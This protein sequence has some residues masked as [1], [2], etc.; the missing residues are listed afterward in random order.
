MHIYIYIHIY[1]YIHVYLHMH[2]QKIPQVTQ[3]ES[4]LHILFSSSIVVIP[5]FERYSDRDRWS[6]H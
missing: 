1:T 5:L 6:C 2:K 4:L 3:K